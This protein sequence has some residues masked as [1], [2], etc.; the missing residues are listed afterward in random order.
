MPAP[1]P[2][3]EEKPQW[4][5]GPSVPGYSSPSGS[6]PPH[7]SASPYAHHLPPVVNAPG[8]PD[9]HPTGQAGPV[10]PPP[11]MSVGSMMGGPRSVPPMPTSRPP[12]SPSLSNVLASGAH[13]STIMAPAPHGPPGDGP[14]MHHH[15]MASSPQ[16]GHPSQPPHHQGHLGHPPHQ[17]PPPPNN[18]PPSAGQGAGPGAGG[19]IGPG[20]PGGPPPPPGPQAIAPNGPPP[21]G[22]AGGPP[23]PSPSPS[24]SNYRPLNVKD[25]LSYLDQVKVQ[26]QEHPDVYNRFL[27]IMKDFKSQNIDTPGVI[28]R[29][30]TLFKGHPSL[31]SGFN[32]FL[33]PGY[34][35]ECSTNPNEVNMIRV[36]TPSGHTTTQ[37][38]AP[39]VIPERLPPPPP[40]SHH[41]SQSS[42]YMQ[43]NPNYQ[44]PIPSI[45][46]ML[47][48]VGSSQYMGPQGPQGMGPGGAGQAGPGGKKT[49]VEFNHA[50]NYV[51]KIKNRF[52]ND[53]DTYKQFLELLQ[54]YQKEMKPIT[55]V[56]SHVTMLFKNAPDLLDEFKQFLPENGNP[57]PDL[58][59]GM[60][61]QPAAPT[62]PLPRSMPVLSTLNNGMAVG[63]FS[64]PASDPYMKKPAISSAQ[65]APSVNKKKRLTG[66]ISDRPVADNL[67]GNNKKRPKHAHAGEAGSPII[68][69]SQPE[70]NKNLATAEELQFFD[71][72]KKFLGNKATYAEF[73][74]LLNLFSQDILDR[75][76][77]VEKV[78]TFLGPNRDLM[79]W[80]KSYVGWD[81]K[82]EIIEN[83]AAYRTKSYRL[84]PK[85]ETTLP[86]SGRDEMCW[87]VLNDVWASHPNWSVEGEGFMPHKKNAYE[88]ALHKCEE[89][90]YEY[91]M[92]IEA[93][94]HTIALLEPIN[95]QIQSMS[96]EERA[97][98]KLPV[99]LGGT[100]KTIYQR[101]IKKIYDKDRGQEVIDALHN[102]PAIAVPVVLKRLKQKDE[103]WKK[104]QRDW[105]KVWREI[106]AKNFYKALDHQGLTFK[107]TDKRMITAK[108]LVAEIEAIR[109]DQIDRRLV[110]SVRPRY[111]FRYFFKDPTIFRDTSDL[112][113]LHLE[114]QNTL[115]SSDREKMESFIREFI[116]QFFCLDSQ[117]MAEDETMEDAT[118]ASGSGHANGT[119]K[120]TENG[121][122]SKGGEAV[123]KAEPKEEAM[124]TGPRIPIL[125]GHK[126]SQSNRALSP[127]N[128]W[129]QVGNYDVKPT[130][131][132]VPAGSSETKRSTLNFFGNLTYYCF[133]RLYQLIYSRLETM[134]NEAEGKG[135]S[136]RRTVNEAAVDLGLQ[137]NRVE[138]DADIKSDTGNNYAKLMRLLTRFIEGEMEQQMFEESARYLFAT[139]AYIVFTMDK[140]ISALLKHVHTIVLDQRCND[141]I[142]M[143]VKDRQHEKNSRRQ[144]IIYRMQADAV[145]GE[146]NLYKIE[147]NKEAQAVSIQLLS[148]N[149]YTLDTAISSEEKWG[150]YIDSYVLLTPT[151]GVAASVVPTFMKRNLPEQMLLDEP[152]QDV[153]TTSGLEIKICINTYK[154]FFVNNTE[155][156]F[157]RNKVA[158]PVTEEKSRELRAKRRSKFEAWLESQR[159]ENASKKENEANQA[160]FDK[161]LIEGPAEVEADE[162]EGR[163]GEEKG[164]K[165]QRTVTKV[166][167]VDEGTPDERKIY[168]TTRVPL[169][170]STTAAAGGD[171]A[172]AGD[173]VTASAAGDEQNTAEPM[174]GVEQ[175]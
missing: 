151:E 68:P 13:S 115:G 117:F 30:S 112:I 56:Y 123:V 120:G 14:D 49:P 46:Q 24:A 66:A 159:E 36:T 118:G 131:M 39:I 18:P 95:K 84:L 34:R 53:P 158:F 44:S 91:D 38:G 132:G 67:A 10:L 173:A 107:V 174:T 141:L 16:P 88:E 169:S 26:F 172:A 122:D 99:G 143:F 164:D 62:P 12:T 149:D 72:V 121:K 152:P 86:C 51:H 126:E 168:T 78:E 64:P 2:A 130:S 145:V 50:I 103:E 11:S 129:I 3:P 101:I 161:W 69:A 83:V 106:D 128:T 4:G 110:P 20:G 93:N 40:P 58:F 17:G 70:P 90:R 167:V 5:R 133:F 102:N 54:A 171:A 146:E 9:S 76:L 113:L 150:Y 89:E 19:P 52:A 97:R 32:T 114:K 48:P 27:D 108:S 111:Q 80:F 23:P 154:I 71:R 65:A 170:A 137:D 92:N 63:D 7:S 153:T 163:G 94:L 79:E 125:G 140:L 138:V 45:S 6:M 87:E 74:K 175:A 98:F 8:G 33:P 127:S 142:A 73:L 57:N 124:P 165:R 147:Y 116:P 1:P 60:M 41:G 31:I 85:N 104:A 81:G 155:D 166:V 96:V 15:H 75:K 157:K 47:P 21:P 29:V 139:K 135:A 105:N 162:E 100:S 22:S 82:D 156:F 136:D 61:P 28:E 77:L 25:A 42:Y 37:M 109:R 119:S 148:K 134:R 59:G 35:I 43:Q 144:Q 55:D 160:N